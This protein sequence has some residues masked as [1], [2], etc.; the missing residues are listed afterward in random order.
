MWVKVVMAG[1]KWLG[2][3]GRECNIVERSA[4]RVLCKG[5]DTYTNSTVGAYIRPNGWG[6]TS[7]VGTQGGDTYTDQLVVIIMVY[8]QSEIV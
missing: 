3:W 5:Q 2:V 1:A 6:L 4:W 8:F 7:R